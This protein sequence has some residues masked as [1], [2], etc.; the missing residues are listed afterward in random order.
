MILAVYRGTKA[1]ASVTR[2]IQV[3]TGIQILTSA[4]PVQCTTS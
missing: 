1:V 4:I 2:K 3:Q